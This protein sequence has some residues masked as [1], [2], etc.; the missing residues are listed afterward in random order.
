MLSEYDADKEVVLHFNG[1]FFVDEV[2]E[3]A[4]Y[5]DDVDIEEIQEDDDRLII[6][7]SN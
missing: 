3:K 2:T 1:E 6:L 5:D 7:L 4:I